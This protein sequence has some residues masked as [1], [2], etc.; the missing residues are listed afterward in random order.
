MA[1]G[2]LTARKRVI[3]Q[4]VIADVGGLLELDDYA[5]VDDRLNKIEKELQAKFGEAF[6]E[7]V[8]NAACDRLDK[9]M[10]D[11]MNTAMQSSLSD[12]EKPGE[13]NA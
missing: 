3:Q 11:F 10:A 4:K 7:D 6:T 8:M 9:L 12:T 1:R 2:N 5:E 13:G